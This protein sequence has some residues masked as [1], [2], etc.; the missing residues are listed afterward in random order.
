MKTPQEIA[1]DVVQEHLSRF[2]GDR[3]GNIPHPRLVRL[4]EHAI[5]AERDETDKWRKAADRDHDELVAI[6]E[7]L[8]I[9]YGDWD[10]PLAPLVGELR[11]MGRALV[12]R[13]NEH[14]MDP[15][16]SLAKAAHGMMNVLSGTAAPPAEL[17][18]DDEAA[19]IG[20]T[21]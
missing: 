12:D 6:A 9:D 2:P 4:I 16:V 20:G 18:P 14:R 13:V 1:R 15:S 21:R 3:H 11:S 8:P 10:G 19:E 7:H 5:Q 17:H